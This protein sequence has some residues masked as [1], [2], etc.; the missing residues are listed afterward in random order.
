VQAIPDLGQIHNANVRIWGGNPRYVVP[1]VS[2]TANSYDASRPT[3]GTDSAISTIT[4]R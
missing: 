3:V 4:L 1:N 2:G